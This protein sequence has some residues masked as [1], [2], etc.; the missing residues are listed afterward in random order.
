[1]PGRRGRRGDLPLEA[2]LASRG[3]LAGAGEGVEAR[4][5]EAQRAV[6]PGVLV[7]RTPRRWYGPPRTPSRLPGAPCPGA[8]R[9]L[10]AS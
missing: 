6:V 8:Y 1:V 3:L 2:A 5:E 10:T 4:L 7:P 9:F